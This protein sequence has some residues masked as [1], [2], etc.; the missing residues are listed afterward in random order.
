MHKIVFFLR[1]RSDVDRAEAERRYADEHSALVL[2]VPGVVRYVQNPVL[3]AATLAGVDAAPPWV[4]GFS[5]IWFEDRGAYLAATSS[6]QWAAAGAAA[7]E[8]F[9]ADW[10]AGGWAAEIEERIKREGLGAPGDG[11]G[12]PPAGPV[13][14]IGILRYRPDIDRDDCNRYWATTH[15]DLALTISQIGHYTHNHAIRPLIGDELAFDGF[16]ES[17]YADDQT[18]REAMASAEWKRLGADGDNLFDMSAF[19]SVIVEERVLRTP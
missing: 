17:W 13:K 18:Y 3:T 16:S 19:K 5:A 2:A 14:L 12:T 7:A 4:D 8:I 6:P 9:D 10:V 15:G 1:F 11:V